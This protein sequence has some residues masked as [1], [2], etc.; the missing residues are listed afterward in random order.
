M[1]ARRG[2]W[3]DLSPRTQ[4]R[5]RA[6]FG[7][8]GAREVRDRR[9]E[10]AYNAGAV[11]HRWEAGHIPPGS[12]GPTAS[13]FAVPV[14]GGGARL[15]R[16]VSVTRADVHRVGRYDG[17]VRKLVAGRMTAA[18]FRRRVAGWR[19]IEV[20]GPPEVAGA[21][22]FAS[23]PA[24]VLSLAVEAQ[25]DPPESWIDS[26]RVRPLPRRRPPRPSGSR[27][28]GASRRGGGTRGAIRHSGERQGTDGEGFFD[29]IEEAL[30]AA[31]EALGEGVEALSESLDDAL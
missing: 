19:P 27:P 3:S 29:L 14:E 15:L 24:K 20:Q 12:V 9:A 21:Y 7:G 28:S 26:G 22:R 11:I 10:A 30:D 18:A 31:G 16:G 25:A 8:N 2:S 1:A 13:F 17:L 23:D 4:A 6:R 5:W